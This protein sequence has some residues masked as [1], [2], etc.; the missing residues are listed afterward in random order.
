MLSH[1]PASIQLVDYVDDGEQARHYQFRILSPNES[2]QHVQPGQF[3][4]LNVPSIGE[5]P[6]T[7]T[8][9]PNEEGIFKAFIRQMGTLTRELFAMKTGDILGARGPLGIGWPL[10][11]IAQQNLL[12]VAGGCGLAPLVN[13]IEHIISSQNL[14][15]EIKQELVL[16]YGAKSKRAQLLTPERQRWEKQFTIFNTLDQAYENELSPFTSHG[17]PVNILEKAIESFTSK[18][19]IAL[20]CGPEPMMNSA[21]Q[22][23]IELGLY[24]ENIFLSIERRMHCGVGLCGHCYVN[25]Q[26]VCKNGP[27]YSWKDWQALQ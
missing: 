16:V 23:L 10:D 17:S 14:E 27:T 26:Y 6:F 12:I 24:P 8:C 25:S 20:L 4:M 3:F 22:R 2:W 5:A 9:P 1:I 18:P 13:L 7:F 19:K 11:N 15:S 21:A